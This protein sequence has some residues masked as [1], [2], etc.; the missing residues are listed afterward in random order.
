MTA[1][2]G[3]YLLYA[4]ISG[5][6]YFYIHPV[7]II[8]VMV[9]GMVLLAVAVLGG[10]APAAA[11]ERAVP[12]RLAL[13]LLALPVAVGFF[14]PARPLGLSMAAQRGVDAHSRSGGSVMFP[15]SP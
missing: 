13:V 3:A 12:T 5:T 9:T 6:L 10:T 11:A 7:Y 15:S 14:L 8:P 4:F 2:F 1:A